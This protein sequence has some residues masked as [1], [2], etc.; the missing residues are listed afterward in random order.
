MR[1]GPFTFDGG[2]RGEY[3]RP[4]EPLDRTDYR[5]AWQSVEVDAA[6]LLS[7]Q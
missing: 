5:D 1:G 7:G 6:D 3:I 2:V 4:P